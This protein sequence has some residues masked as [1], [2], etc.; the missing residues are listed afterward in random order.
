MHKRILAVIIAAV[1][2][3][4]AL[5]S[6]SNNQPVA[7]AP[8]VAAPAPVV[9]QQ[10]APQVVYQQPSQVIVER[11][12]SGVGSFVAGAATGAIVHRALS[13]PRVVYVPHSRLVV[14]RRYYRRF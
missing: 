2:I 4:T 14:R 5:V 7:Q 3:A 13:R 8:V 12:D 10:P 11:H 1:V 9:V 6:C